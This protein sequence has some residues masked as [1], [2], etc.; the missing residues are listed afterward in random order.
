[1]KTIITITTIIIMKSQRNFLKIMKKSLITIIIKN[2]IKIM[3]KNHL[4]KTSIS[5][6]MIKKQ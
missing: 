2:S 3:I 1:M 4:I 5:M 6:K